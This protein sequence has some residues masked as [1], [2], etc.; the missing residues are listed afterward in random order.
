[1]ITVFLVM[2]SSVLA[3]AF[4][5]YPAMLEDKISQY[6]RSEILQTTC[7]EATSQVILQTNDP[8]EKVAAFYKQELQKNGLHLEM[9]TRQATG[10]SIIFSDDKAGGMVGVHEDGPGKIIVSIVYSVE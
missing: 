1:M 8:M 7:M 5:N 10:W 2:A 9:E 4:M 3:H 6:P